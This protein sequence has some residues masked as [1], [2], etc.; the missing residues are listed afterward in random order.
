M[1]NSPASPSVSYP[2]TW[3]ADGPNSL[4]HKLK[5]NGFSRID[6]LYRHIPFVFVYKKGQ[7]GAILEKVAANFSDVLNESFHTIGNHLSGDITSDKFGPAL[8]WNDLHW[9]GTSLETPV[10]DKVS[11]QVFGLDN[12]G[13]STLLATVRPAVD[14][15][16]SWIN[17][18][19]YPYIKLKMLNTDSLNATPN[20]LRYWRVNGT[21][22][23]EGA[24]APNI[25]FAMKDTA[26]QGELVD[27]KLAFKNISQ[28]AFADSMK[29]N[30]TITDRN[31]N[32]TQLNIPKGK[33]LISG[34][35]LVINYKINTRNYPGMNTVFVDVNPANTQ[36]EQYHFNNIL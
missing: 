33:V 36:P 7:P 23:P 35:T 26:E 3:Q 18:Q 12:N 34:D 4:Y 14:T 24:V 16:L 2:T 20:Q 22:I 8:Q 17:A 19:T 27:F 15:T 10:S 31:N 13:N 6:S 30:F 28:T 25:L 5:N 11:V 21:Y 1:S 9:R 29:I 32:P